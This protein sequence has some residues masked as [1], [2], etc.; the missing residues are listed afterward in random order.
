VVQ[1]VETL[2][3]GFVLEIGCGASQLLCALAQRNCDLHGIGIDTNPEMIAAGRANII[4]REL[5][6]RIDLVCGDILESE[7]L[8]A[9][10]EMDAVDVIVA[11]SVVNSYF[12]GSTGQS[13]DTFLRSLQ[14]RFPNRVM[15]ICDYFGRLGSLNEEFEGWQRTLIHD[16]TQLISGQGIPPSNSAIWREIYE[17]NACALI[18]DYE[19]TS[20]GISWFIHLIQL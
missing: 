1:L 9:A 14:I 20:D 8:I 4:K 13:I 19:G 6:G 18:Q 16:V 10:D 3:V 11:V 5:T 17:R 7:G 12:G 2:G 15:I